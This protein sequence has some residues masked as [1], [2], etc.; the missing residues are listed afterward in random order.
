MLF[1]LVI[2]RPVFS[3]FRRVITLF[4]ILIFQLLLEGLLIK[5]LENYNTGVEKSTQRVFDD[6][7][8]NYF[9][10]TILAI[11]IAFPVEMFLMIAFSRRREEQPVLFYVALVTV[12]AITIGSFIGI[13]ILAFKFCFEWSGYWAASFLWSILLEIFF[14]QFLY[15]VVRYFIFRD[16]KKDYQIVSS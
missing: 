5:G 3:R 15:M 2:Y 12:I 6:Y 4:T 8:G 10:Y 9:G 1:G 14:L 11:T 7:V 13:F 16:G